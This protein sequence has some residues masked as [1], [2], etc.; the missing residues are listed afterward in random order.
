[1]RLFSL[2][3]LSFALLAQQ[4]DKKREYVMTDPIPAD[5]IPAAPVLE[6]A[7]ALKSIQVQ[8]GFAF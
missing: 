8:D 2:C 7:D 4:G 3:L 6:V 5:Q 1:M